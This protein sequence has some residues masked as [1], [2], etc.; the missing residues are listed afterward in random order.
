MIDFDSIVIGI[1]IHATNGI[2]LVTCYALSVRVHQE[3]RSRTLTT[4]EYKFKFTIWEMQ[5]FLVAIEYHMSDR[6]G[7]TER[8][9]INF[10]NWP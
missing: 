8:V 1:C 9:K 3:L 7:T 2:S 5:I 10:W 4:A 6:N